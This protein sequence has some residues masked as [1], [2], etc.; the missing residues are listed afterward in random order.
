MKRL[1]TIAPTVLILGCASIAGPPPVDT[2]QLVAA[3]FKVVDV[4]APLQIERL[5]TLPTG[6]LT[7]YQFT[8][9]HLYLYPNAPMKQLYVGR[10]A[11]YQA[12]LKLT[13]GTPGPSLAQQA[14][15]DTANY[16]KQDAG[17][18]KL[19]ARDEN[20]PYWWSLDN[21]GWR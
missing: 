18:A 14:T 19:T 11:E 5:Q 10:P 13:G 1:L 4:Q 8:G 2:T 21:I 20:D 15:A 3:G 7:E 6:K 12:Y 17:M 16:A 9:K